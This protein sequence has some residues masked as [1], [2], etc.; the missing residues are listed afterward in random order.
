M[1]EHKATIIWS[2]GGKD[3]SYKSY[4]RDHLWR[5]DN[6]VGTFFA[7]DN[8]EGRPI[9]VRFLWSDITPSS[10]RWQQAFSEDGGA[11]WETNWVMDFER[12]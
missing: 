12:T 5:F 11:T 4:S 2:R 10:A 6:G 3:F 9:R 1:S 7:D 8:L